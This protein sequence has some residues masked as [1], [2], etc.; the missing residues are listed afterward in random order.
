MKSTIAEWSTTQAQ[1][2]QC[3]CMRLSYMVSTYSSIL[4]ALYTIYIPLNLLELQLLYIR[5]YNVKEKIVRTLSYFFDEAAIYKV[6]SS[7]K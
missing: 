5:L 6:K 4:C 7:F 3:G 1:K 2:L